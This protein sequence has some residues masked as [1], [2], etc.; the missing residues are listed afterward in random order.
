MVD[1][2][3]PKKLYFSQKVKNNTKTCPECEKALERSRQ[4]Y[5]ITYFNGPEPTDM[6]QYTVACSA[7]NF[8]ESCDVVVLNM[9]EFNTAA[10]KILGGTA[11]RPRI[12]YMVFGIIPEGA[13]MNDPDG[14]GGALLFTNLEE[15]MK[16]AQEKSQ[17]KPKKPVKVEKTPGRNEPCSCGSGVKYKKCCMNK[18]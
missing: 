16:E 11:Q 4:N 2:S 5:L 3:M 10:Q 1:A 6:Q 8:C 9:R 17:A 15:I 7:G 14:L 13:T 12:N 18:V